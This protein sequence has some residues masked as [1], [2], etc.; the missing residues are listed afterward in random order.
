[1]TTYYGPGASGSG[2]AELIGYLNG[3]NYPGFLGYNTL[4][5]KIFGVVFAVSGR[6]CVGKEGPLAH[7]GANIGAMA[8]YLHPAFEFLRNDDTKRSIIAAGGSAGVAAAF[9]A[10]IGGALFSYEMSKSSDFWTF[11]MIWRTFI[12]CAFAVLTLGAFD[13]GGF[14]S[15]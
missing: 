5:T 12:T 7:I 2:V 11:S 4:I 13:M 15:T 1:M 9:G 8:P 6:L 3:V 10:P 14:G